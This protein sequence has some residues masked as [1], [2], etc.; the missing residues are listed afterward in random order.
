[1]SEDEVFEEVDAWLSAA[2]KRHHELNE[3][4]AEKKPNAH[5]SPRS[6]TSQI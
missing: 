5:P 2:H 6:I 3:A 4:A 1:M